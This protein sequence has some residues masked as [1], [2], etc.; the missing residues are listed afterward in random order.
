MLIESATNTIGI[1]QLPAQPKTGFNTSRVQ[2]ALQI[3][4]QTKRTLQHHK[5]DHNRIQY[6]E[7]KEHFYSAIKKARHLQFIKKFNSASIKSNS[8]QFWSTYTNYINRHTSSNSS[9]ESASSCLSAANPV[10]SIL[11][12]SP[13]EALNNLASTFS[14]TSIINET[15]F[16]SAATDSNYE[17]I[18]HRTNKIPQEVKTAMNYT[19]K[20]EESYNQP[21]NELELQTSIKHLPKSTSSGADLIHP[22]FIK[23][24][25][26]SFISELLSLFNICFQHHLVP[27]EWKHARIQ[28]I[29]KKGDKTNSDN[30]RPI[31]ITSLLQEHM[32]GFYIQD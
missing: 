25:P 24:A 4:R 30:Y 16:T 22:Q 21:M 18:Q 7:S 27:N 8:K 20:N 32:K 26:S 31:S 9:S 6:K 19:D 29:H 10:N 14:N 12:S 1:K 2:A 28:P 15:N 23:H 11:P 13:T 3:M 5:D 17:S